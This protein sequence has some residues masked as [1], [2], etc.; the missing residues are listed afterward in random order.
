MT[1]QPERNRPLRILTVY[2]HPDDEAFGPSASLARYA[3]DGAEIQG[4]FAT[5]GEEGNTSVEPV[6]SPEDLAALR[7]QD[8][9]DAGEVIGY[10]MLH[11]LRYH[12]GTLK[13][14]PTDE[15]S[16]RVYSII[17]DF[18]PDI[19]TTF[20]PAGITGHPDHCAVHHA[21]VGAV[22]KAKEQ[23][24]S[25]S[26]LFYDTVSGDAV[27]EM[28]LADSPDGQTNTWID[29]TETQHLKVEALRIHGRHIRDAADAADQM[30]Q[31][32]SDTHWATFHRAWPVVPD[33]E[34][35][36]GFLEDRTPA[37]SVATD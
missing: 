18:D 10:R 4:I 35:L 31:D 37:E 9:R 11:F 32:T 30:E 1:V 22:K 27:E 3:R 34:T 24:L 5:T 36:Y 19:V 7:E 2:A 26:A 29:V 8:T 17:E 20:G 6:P 12:D 16:R 28:G 25:V 14:V 23:G 13:D 15:L 33:G 21:T